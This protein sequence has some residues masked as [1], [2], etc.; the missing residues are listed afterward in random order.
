MLVNYVRE[1]NAFHRFANDNYL[2]SGERL[3][4][5]GLMDYINLHF[6]S[7]PQWPGEFISIPNKGLLSHVPF[8]EDALFEARNR[9]KQRG[10]IEYIPGKKNKEAP[11][12][13]MRYFAEKLSTSYQ[14]TYP[15]SEEG[16]PEKTCKVTG[17]TGGNLGGKVAGKDGGSV[18]DINL[19]VNPNGNPYE[20]DD[21]EAAEE[22]ARETARRTVE[23]TFREHFG[24][25][26]TIA[27]ANRIAVVATQMG[28]ESGVVREAVR[29][30]A[31]NG[32]KNPAMYALAILKSW[33]TEYIRTADDLADWQIMRDMYEGRGAFDAETVSY[34]ALE[35][36][37]KR[38]RE[39]AE[40]AG[41]KAKQ[42]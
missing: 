35:E 31:E 14:Q 34:T 1:I 16:Y 2:S 19:N 7:G 38:R 26:A 5:F 32:A 10:L 39:A 40:A 24:R 15:Q 42:G 6:A 30:A 8:G 21:E 18:G 22:S 25:S 28:M 27:E 33:S 29:E 3:L 4:W 12:Y 20:D 36:A 37:R 41:R 17:N 9:L 11:Q 23:A 13:R